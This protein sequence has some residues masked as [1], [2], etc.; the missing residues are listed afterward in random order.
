[1]LRLRTGIINLYVS[2][3]ANLTAGRSNSYS[4]DAGEATMVIE[5][6]DSLTNALLGRVFDRQTAGYGGGRRTR[7]TNR[8]DFLQ[9][10]RTWA[11][12]SVHGLDGLKA[13]SP[14]GAAAAR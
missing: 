7:V 3:P 1:M 9:M 4:I 11:A 5:A 13:R 8:E 6:R 10:F 2:A 12:G 14:V